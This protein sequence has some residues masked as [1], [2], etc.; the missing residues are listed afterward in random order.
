MQ[1]CYFE[2]D[3]L[4]RRIPVSQT[5]LD[6]LVNQ[7][8]LKNKFQQY[9]TGKAKGEA[10]RLAEV[11]SSLQRPE[12][13]GKTEEV[14]RPVEVEEAESEEEDESEAPNVYRKLVDVGD[15]MSE[16][17]RRKILKLLSEMLLRYHSE[18]KEWYRQCVE[19]NE[20]PY[21]EGFFMDLT[22]LW[23]FVVSNRLANGKLNLVNFSRSFSRLGK[24]DFE[25]YFE[26]GLVEE[27]VELSRK[28][29]FE[30]E[31]IEQELSKG[32]ESGYLDA[33]IANI[34]VDDFEYKSKRKARQFEGNKII[35]FR[36]FV[37]CLIS[38]SA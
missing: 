13:E 35:L 26:A 17:S 22:S 24:K 19:L 21:E 11:S 37:N 32:E 18:M 25:L 7:Q 16:E 31:S 34:L 15:L 36:S 14:A 2:N 10:S 20:R 1:Y 4:V 28:Y 9:K 12:T 30:A 6:S 27:S 5:L 33:K 38:R 8:A 3:K 23:K 29:D